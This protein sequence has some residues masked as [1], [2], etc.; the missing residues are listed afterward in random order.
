MNQVRFLSALRVLTLILAMVVPEMYANSQNVIQGDWTMQADQFRGQNGQR[1]TISFPGGGT[2]SARVWGTDLFTD[3]SSIASAAVHSGLISPQYGGTVTIEIRPGAEAYQGSVRNGVTS[4]PYG[5]FSGSFLFIGTG[6][7]NQPGTVVQGTWT[8]QA[9]VYRGQNGKRFTITFPAGGTLS[10]RLWGT[11]LYTDDSSIGSAAVHAG[12]ITPQRGGTVTIEIRPG[13]EVYQ[14]ST[15]NGVT[16]NPYGAFSG[17]FVLVG[18]KV[19]AGGTSEPDLTGMWKDDNGSTYA[20]R[21]VNNQVWWYMDAKPARANV[22]RGTL[23]GNVLTGE[24]CD[25]PGGKLDGKNIGKLTL[26][27]VNGDRLEKVADSP[28]PYGG[29][30]WTRIN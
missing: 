3:D 10:T 8:M 7:M 15:R 30:A 12:L 24:W 5:S 28:F 18:S 19:A 2:V 4:N 22:F 6:P 11:D 25:V 13:A 14:G 27:V 17:S 9:D 29:S 26:K 23:S 20:I 21:H 1:F 16:S